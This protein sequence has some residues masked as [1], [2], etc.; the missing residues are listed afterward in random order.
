M[1]WRSEAPCSDMDPKYFELPDSTLPFDRDEVIR[2][3]VIGR[4][5]CFNC[6]STFPCRESAEPEDF[7]TTIRG[8]VLPSGLESLEYEPF[9]TKKMGRPVDKTL[10]P[11][12][13]EEIARMPLVEGL[14]RCPKGHPIS[15]AL[16][17]EAM[18][19]PSEW[20]YY[21]VAGDGRCRRCRKTITTRHKKRR[22]R[23]M[24]Q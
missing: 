17:T 23:G 4:G 12:C 7:E 8:G 19:A 16:K 15:D 14:E 6:P 3:L 13:L 18:I 20:R 11:E 21:G 22:Q 24:V 5:A 9:V 10:S 2:N 1:T